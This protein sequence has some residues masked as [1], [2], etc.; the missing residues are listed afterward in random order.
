MKV[1]YIEDEKEVREPIQEWFSYTGHEFL[2]AADTISGYTLAVA[3]H[4]DIIL[5]DLML[6]ELD[7]LTLAFELGNIPDLQNSL[8]L[9]VT[10]ADN[11]DL[12]KPALAAGCAGYIYKPF[13][14]SELYAR[15]M[16]YMNGRRDVID[17]ADSV[18][19]LRSSAAKLVTMLKSKIAER[20]RQ[21]AELQAAQEQ[22]IRTERL[23]ATG[24]LGLRMA[25]ELN[26]PLQAVQNALELIREGL[27]PS[28]VN[29]DMLRLFDIGQR[30]VK[31]ASRLASSLLDVHTPGANRQ[32]LVDW[33]DVIN[34]VMT[35][36]RPV[37][38]R[39]AIQTSVPTERGTFIVPGVYAD[40]HQIIRNL[41]QN[42][43]ES[44]YDDPRNGLKDNRQAEKP[45]EAQSK[46]AAPSYKGK[47]SIEITPEGAWLRLVVR[48]TGHGLSEKD[49]EKLSELFYTTRTDGHGI[50][51][52]VC[53][54]IARANNARLSWRNNLD[55]GATFQLLWPYNMKV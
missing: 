37:A 28:D 51:L 49:L 20:D 46:T 6:G 5:I 48:D 39:Q 1:L 34:D 38:D 44:M 22:L 30:E 32:S 16:L 14:P 21:Y 31:R 35:L 45:K 47:L 54:L 17:D 3:E 41:A 36:I 26:N 12:I 15:L 55:H 27:P 7:G 2:V 24:Q 29:P 8:R 52:Y 11:R 23:V 33:V 19:Y 40:M 4:P 9:V 42:A 13:S 43:L 25:H 18:T 50:G 10:A 53:T